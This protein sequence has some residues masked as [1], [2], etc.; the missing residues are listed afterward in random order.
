MPEGNRFLTAGDDKTIKMWKT[1]T[2]DWGE[3]EEPVNTYISRV[4]FQMFLMLICN[5]VERKVLNCEYH[6]IREI[7][8]N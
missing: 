4:K 2:P 3:E 6:K 5:H 8:R 7:T 1:E